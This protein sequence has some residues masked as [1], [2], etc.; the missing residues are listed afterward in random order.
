MKYRGVFPTVLLSIVL[1]GCSSRSPETESPS[2]V[3]TSRPASDATIRLEPEDVKA[4]GL[5]SVEVV[6]TRIAPTLVAP[7]HVRTRSGGEAEIFS[8]FPGRLTGELALPRIGD[9]VRKEQH[10]A[11]VEQQFAAPERLQLTTTA[12]ELQT[13]IEHAQQELDLKRTELSRAQELYDGGA[14]PLKQLQTAQFE[15]K[16]AAATLE[17]ARRSKEQYDAAQSSVNT[18]ARRAPITAPI[19]G[20]VV[21]VD[22]ALGQQVD[23]AKSLLT[24]ADL[25]TVWVEAAVH[26]RDLPKLRTV[27]EAQIAI[28]GGVTLTGRLVTIGSLVDPENRTVPVIFSVENRA[29]SLKIEMFVETR[30]PIGA[31]VPALVIPSASLLSEQGT[32]A[33]YVETSPG[34]YQRRAVEIGQRK[35]DMVVVTAGLQK[36]E[37][38]VAI[39]AQTLRGE[40]LKGQIP[41]EEEEKEREEKR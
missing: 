32:Y 20:T 3:E 40:S 1:A 10:I 36:G 29:A 38:V 41:V 21:A 39:G 13:N 30:I 23:P 27:R 37:R 14:I 31:L 24:I 4:N 19:S 15:L 18:Q 11:D 16:Q 26:E 9:S 6:E 8:P 2:S 34:T 35:D 17:G 7:G 5:Q 33:V 12:I 25:S 28:P 22:A